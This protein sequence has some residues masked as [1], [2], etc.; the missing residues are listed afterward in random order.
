[1]RSRVS[2]MCR[3]PYTSHRPS[4]DSVGRNADAEGVSAHRRVV[5][6]LSAALGE[7]DPATILAEGDA[8]LAGNVGSTTTTTGAGGGSIRTNQLLSLAAVHRGG[9]E[10]R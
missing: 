10:L 1:M 6:P 3:V 5:D 8:H 9:S 2:L 4:G 7:P